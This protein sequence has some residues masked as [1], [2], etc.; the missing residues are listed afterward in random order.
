MA[1]PED[2]EEIMAKRVGLCFVEEVTDYLTDTLLREDLKRLITEDRYWK[3]FVEAAELS[4][5][6]EAALRAALKG[7]LSQEPADKDDRCQWELQRKRFLE[8]FPWLKSKLEEDIRKLHGLADHL[9]EVHW[10][11]TTSNVV[12]SSAGIGAGALYLCSLALTPVTGGLSLVL[13]ATSLGL[14]VAASLN[15][16]TTTVVEELNRLSDE[17]EAK[18]LVG[19]SMD[20]L[21]EIMKITPKMSV[22]LYKTPGEV[23]DDL[24]SLRVHIQAL[25]I[26]RASTRSA[27]GSRQVGRASSS[28]LLPVTRGARITAASF[29]SIF[30]VLDVYHLVKD[31]MHLYDGAKTESAGALRNLAHKLE[32]RLHEFK[33]IHKAL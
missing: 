14:G 9:D 32:E 20:T 10:G 6:E 28:S 19:A 15:S 21:E 26:A 12:S 30:L 16:L 25:R 23:V 24:R 8:V 31:S 4:R 22:K 17:S 29:T 33:K 18:R 27:Q 1:C 7:H 11:C 2:P 3:A 5:E 13:S